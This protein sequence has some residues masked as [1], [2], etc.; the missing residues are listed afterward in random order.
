[1]AT[2]ARV[3]DLT[4][5]QLCLSD[6]RDSTAILAD[7]AAGALLTIHGTP[8]IVINGRLFEGALSPVDLEKEVQRALARKS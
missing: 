4:N 7:E 5:F 3:P 6:A 2:A 1:M 8:T